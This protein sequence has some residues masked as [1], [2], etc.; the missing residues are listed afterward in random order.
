MWDGTRILFNEGG[1]TVEG[2]DQGF[3]LSVDILRMRVHVTGS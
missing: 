3:V 2:S 1:R